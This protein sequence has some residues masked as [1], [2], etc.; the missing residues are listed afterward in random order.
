MSAAAVS[1]S[2]RGA[3]SGGSPGWLEAL[4]QVGPVGVDDPDCRSSSSRQ[5]R[6]WAISR[7]GA[8]SPSRVVVVQVVRA[9]RNWAASRAVVPSR[10][11]A[12]STWPPA[13]VSAASSWAVSRAGSAG[14]GVGEFHQLG[15]ALHH[16]Q[17]P[18]D[19]VPVGRHRRLIGVADR[20]GVGVQQ[21]AQ[22]GQLAGQRHRLGQVQGVHRQRQHACRRARRAGCGWSGSP[23]TPRH[24]RSARPSAAP[25]AGPARSRRG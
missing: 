13:A 11:N 7:A 12:S 19:Q 5:A 8:G 18:A 3:G 16:V 14:G 17:H 4:P 22:A 21:A 1:A 23:G 6:N 2:R 25:T 20:P 24:G 10:K 9:S 15:V